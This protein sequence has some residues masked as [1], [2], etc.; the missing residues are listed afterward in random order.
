[1]KL[2]AWLCWVLLAAWSVLGAREF[3]VVVYNVENLFDLDGV[4]LYSQYEQDCCGPYGLE[5]LMRK[6]EAIRCTLAKFNDGEGPEI[7]LFQELELDRTPYGTLDTGAFLRDTRGRP[8]REILE[9]ERWGRNLPAELLLLKYLEDHGMG[10]Y[11]IAAPDPARMETHPPHQN[12]VFSR[13]PISHVRQRPKHEARDL[14]EV[15]IDVDGHAFIVLNNHWKS[16]ASNPD[17]EPVRVQNARVVRARLDALLLQ[18]PRADILIAGDLNSHYNQ[19]AVLPDLKETGVNCVLGAHGFESRMTGGGDHAGL[20][21]LWFEL[22]PEER[23]SE[24]WRGR[25]GTLM[26]ML[27]TPGLYDR[28]GI[29]YVDNSFGRLMVPGFNVDTRWQRPVAWSNYGGGGGVSDHLPIYARFRVIPG[30]GGEGW[31]ELDNPTNEALTPHQPVVPFERMDRRAVPPLQR[32][33]GMSPRE[34]V[35]QMGEVFAISGPL[36]AAGPARVKAG[37]LTL[38]IF[39]PVPSVREALNA[40]QPGD[41]LRAF[42]DLEDWRGRL[43]L[44]IRHASWLHHPPPPAR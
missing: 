22:P 20:Y 31:K 32:L 35:G 6:L 43:Q 40:L 44:V 27:V 4:A 5:P 9:Q 17:T 34:R 1:M 23:G 8:L 15:G 14:L 12:V 7:V 29:Q 38:E 10:G 26:Q 19:R 3:T 39:S 16:G 33:A 30:A 36:H 24:V 25:W 41:E 11:H 42:A 21:N 18:N 37:D 2:R 28:R 13:F